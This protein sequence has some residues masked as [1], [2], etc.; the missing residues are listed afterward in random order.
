MIV[1]VLRVLLAIPG[2]NT[3]KDK[4]QVV[5]SILDT[6]RNRFHVSAAEI[7]H[8]D[9]Y[10]RAGLGFA[11]VSNDKGVVDGTLDRILDLIESNPLCEV[12]ESES[13]FI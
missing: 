4:R 12:V 3:L 10:R 8:L 9:V 1:G 13:D 11:C 2:S 6:A 7:D 5:R